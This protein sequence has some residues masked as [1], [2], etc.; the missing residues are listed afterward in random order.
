MGEVAKICLGGLSLSV[1]LDLRNITKTSGKQTFG[2][3]SNYVTLEY[4]L[5]AFR[6]DVLSGLRVLNARVHFVPHP[7][8]DTLSSSVE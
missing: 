5:D 2:R 3:S 7:R 4:E 6:V 1:L 8:S